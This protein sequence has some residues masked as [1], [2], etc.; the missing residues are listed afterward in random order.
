MTET[1]IPEQLITVRSPQGKRLFDLDPTACVIYL[2]H[3]D[4]LAV[5]DLRALIP[6]LKK[7]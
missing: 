4:E 6:E 7:P 5:I 3:R 1:P 2:K